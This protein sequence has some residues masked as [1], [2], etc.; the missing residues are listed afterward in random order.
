[1][2]TKVIYTITVRTGQDG[3]RAAA[4]VR[5]MQF[6]DGTTESQLTTAF[7]Q[8]DLDTLIAILDGKKPISTAMGGE[9]CG[10]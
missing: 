3:I 8:E 9:I 5:N 4:V 7:A 1:M 10:D 6:S 2:E